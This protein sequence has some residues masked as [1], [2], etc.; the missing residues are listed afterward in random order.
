MSHCSTCGECIYKLDHHCMWTQ[1]CIG[2]CNQ[3]PFI[4]F[5][6]YMTIG[7]FQ[8]WISTIRA[9]SI[10]TATC[11]SQFFSVFEPGVYILWGITCFSAGVVGLMI[12]GLAISHSLMVST[13]YTTLDSIKKKMN[14]PLPVCECRP[15]YH[16]NEHVYLLLWKI[17]TFDRGEIQNLRSL[18][19]TN[20]LTFW[21]PF[22]RAIE[23]EFIIE[24]MNPQPTKLQL[25][26]YTTLYDE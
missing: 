15:L 16:S 3:R 22:G 26:R 8:F 23:N 21:L 11:D 7:V 25:M 20:I 5:C 9:F 6:F 18:F 24:A 14:G 1:T 19:G 13:N 2:H 12:V 4:L 10:M 17:N